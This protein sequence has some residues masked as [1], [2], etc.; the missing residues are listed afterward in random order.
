MTSSG[1]RGR[2]AFLLRCNFDAKQLLVV[3]SRCEMTPSEARDDYANN[4]KC[5][6]ITSL[7]SFYEEGKRNCLPD[8]NVFWI[9]SM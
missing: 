7:M 9:L 3:K 5:T 1:D 2:C 6:T 4:L 8:T